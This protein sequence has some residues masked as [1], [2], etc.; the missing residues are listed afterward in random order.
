MIGEPSRGADPVLRA[1]EAGSWYPRPRSR[2]IA[3]TG[4]EQSIASEMASGSEVPI[5]L[6][7]LEKG[8]HRK[9]SF[10]PT[11]DLPSIPS[12]GETP[13]LPSPQPLPSGPRRRP[14][15]RQSQLSGGWFGGCDPAWTCPRKILRVSG[16]SNKGS[17]RRLSL[18]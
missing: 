14:W 2:E 6:A 7:S 8:M 5:P 15:E 13:Q 18:L 11:P 10:L 17:S 9:H 3:L 4:S 1:G 12:L 16:S